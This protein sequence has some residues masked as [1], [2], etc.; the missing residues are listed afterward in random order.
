MAAFMSKCENKSGV[1]LFNLIIYL[2]KNENYFKKLIKT[3]LKTIPCRIIFIIEDIKAIK[4][5]LSIIEKKIIEIRFASDYTPLLS[6]IL[7]HLLPDL[8]I[9][10]FWTSKHKTALLTHLLTIIDKLIIDSEITDMASLSSLNI[11]TID[12]NWIRIKKLKDLFLSVC[13]TDENLYMLKHARNITMY[14]GKKFTKKAVLFQ[15]WLS[16]FLNWRLTNKKSS[17]ITYKKRDRSKVS[18]HLK[19]QKKL[20]DTLRKIKITTDDNAKLL[21]LKQKN[22]TMLVKISTK[23]KCELPISYAMENINKNEV[24]K[25]ALFIHQQKQ[26]T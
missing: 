3:L 11:N 5:Y 2:D 7:A 8:P 4:P 24:F 13:H 19:K 14:H 21:F 18:I 25:R 6:I 17:K 16:T 26:F 1:F 20:N 9:C 22:N 12:L 15:K 10:L 23:E